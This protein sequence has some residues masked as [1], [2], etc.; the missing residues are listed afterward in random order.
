MIG[1]DY[2]TIYD[3]LELDSA[4]DGDLWWLGLIIVALSAVVVAAAG[5]LI[6]RAVA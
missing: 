4:G 2:P 1:D 5:W 6:W 3:G